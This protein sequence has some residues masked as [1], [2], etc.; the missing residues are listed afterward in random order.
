[1]TTQELSNQFDILYNNAS[2]SAPGL[3]EYEKSV[4]LTKAE[5]DLVR[6][7]FNSRTVKTGE[8]FDDSQKRQYDFSTL[9]RTVKLELKSPLIMEFNGYQKDFNIFDNRSLI[10]VAPHDFFLSINE[11]IVDNNNRRYS[12][13]PISYS[14]YNRLMLKPYGYPLKRQA[15]RII[16][17]SSPTLGEYSCTYVEL[18]SGTSKFLTV[19]RSKSSK[20]L[21]FHIRRDSLSTGNTSKGPIITVK[22]K[23]IDIQLLIPKGKMF[24]YWN[25]YLQNEDALKKGKLDEYIYPLDGNINGIWTTDDINPVDIYI[26]SCKTQTGESVSA[27][28]FEIIGNF[29]SFEIEYNMRY[30]RTPKPIILVDLS[31]VQEGLSIDGY[32]EITECELPANMHEEILQRAVELAK[33]TYQGDLNSI[34]QTGNISGTE[35]GYQIKQN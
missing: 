34:I 6:D 29:P 33:A 1:M 21:F 17:D 4:I 19:I 24:N 26:P 28:V 30:V 15:W 13:L 18:Q 35:L 12:V 8:G 25:M 14:E 2:N 5:K 20:D 31:E 10:Y 23:F 16:S 32:N 7:Y 9:L 3:D 22:D 11:S 27:P